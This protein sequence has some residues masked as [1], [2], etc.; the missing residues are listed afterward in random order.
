V[1]TPHLAGAHALRV[2]DTVFDEMLVAI[3]DHDGG[4]D[5]LALAA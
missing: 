5:A 3:A 2:T 4:R 1:T